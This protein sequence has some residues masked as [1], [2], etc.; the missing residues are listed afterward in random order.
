MVVGDITSQQFDNAMREYNARK[1]IKPARVDPSPTQGSDMTAVK[2]AG[3]NLLAEGPQMN[4]MSVMQLPPPSGGANNE[5]TQIENASEKEALQ[6]GTNHTG[7]YASRIGSLSQA[8]DEDENEE[9][10]EP[11][12]QPPQGNQQPPQGNQQTLPSSLGV[13]VRRDM[14]QGM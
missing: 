8:M 9:E 4:N 11:S 13:A 7:E 5:I 14:R 2:D 10:E 3:G 1:H 6:T 12:Q